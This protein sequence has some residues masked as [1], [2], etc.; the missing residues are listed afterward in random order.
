MGDG[1]PPAPPAAGLTPAQMAHWHSEGY[2]I[3][4]QLLA[5]DID[6]ITDEFESIVPGGDNTMETDADRYG[7]SKDGG[8][9][10][11]DGTQSTTIV[12]TIDHSERLR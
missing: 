3:F 11:Y 7:Y 10:P 2:L 5:D 12:P 4:K 8:M 6:W 1:H 9:R